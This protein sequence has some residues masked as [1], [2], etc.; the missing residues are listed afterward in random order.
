MWLLESVINYKV[1]HAH[2]CGENMTDI[3]ILKETTVNGKSL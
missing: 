1:N 2:M 3:G